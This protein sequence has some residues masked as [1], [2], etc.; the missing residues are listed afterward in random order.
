MFTRNHSRNRIADRPKPAVSAVSA[1]GVDLYHPWC[2]WIG[3]LM[4]MTGVLLHLPDFIS[5]ESMGYRM[6]G[7]PMSAIMLWGMALIIL[8]LPLSVYGLLPRFATL[9]KHRPRQIARYHI[10]AMDDVSLT[11]A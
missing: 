2:F 10:K 4:S 1:I 5:M 7:M 6:S 3:V 11:S 8:G 9:L